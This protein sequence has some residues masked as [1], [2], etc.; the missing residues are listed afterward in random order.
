MQVQP[1][2]R[3][4]GLRTQHGRSYGIGH[5]TNNNYLLNSYVAGSV[6][7]LENTLVN[8]TDINPALW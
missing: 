5:K 7:D 8:K 1:P 2:A 6:V 3:H 4:S